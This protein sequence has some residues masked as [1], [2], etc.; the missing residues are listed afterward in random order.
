MLVSAVIPFVT[1]KAFNLKAL[2]IIF[3]GKRLC[4]EAICNTETDYFAPRSGL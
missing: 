4:E 1:E 2:A 3:I